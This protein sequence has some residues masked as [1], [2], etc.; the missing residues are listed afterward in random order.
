MSF[1][2]SSSYGTTH[3]DAPSYARLDSTY[4]SLYALLAAPASSS[5]HLA[6]LPPQALYSSLTLYLS[7][8]PNLALA[9]FVQTLATSRCLWF[10]HDVV[11]RGADGRL[12]E[13]LATPL[14]N[15][16]SQSA[17]SLLGR[18]YQVHLAAARA[19]LSRID[20]I[21]ATQ[22]G[23]GS[24]SSQ[25][26]LRAWVEL[27]HGSL[28]D[29][30]LDLRAPSEHMAEVPVPRLALLTGLVVGLS[31]YK[32]QRGDSPRGEDGKSKTIDVRTALRA[33]ESHW[34]QAFGDAIQQLRGIDLLNVTPSPSETT[35]QAESQWERE[36]ARSTG[37]D[38]FTIVKQGR[39]SAEA[40][41]A[42]LV[43][44][45]LAAQAASFVSDRA[46]AA[47]DPEP[48]LHII[49]L[50]VL[51]LFDAPLFRLSLVP[52]Q[53]INPTTHA[54]FNCLGPLSRLLAIAGESIALKLRRE[55]VE[56]LL[57]GSDRARY[58]TRHGLFGL[59]AAAEP[60]RRWPGVVTQLL[61]SA[62]ELERRFNDSRLGSTLATAPEEA[63][64]A[65][66]TETWT[67]LKSF[68]FLVVQFF[69]SVLNGLVTIL[70]SP[71]TSSVDLQSFQ[72][73]RGESQNQ[74]GA[75]LS[76]TLSTTSNIPPGILEVLQAQIVAIM[77]LTF[78]IFSTTRDETSVQNSSL[79][80][81]Q[82]TSNEIFARFT[83]YRHVFYGSLEVIKSDYGASSS[84]IEALWFDLARQD[85]VAIPEWQFVAKV[86]V[87]LDI[88]EQLVPALPIALIKTP[89]LEY[90]RPHLRISDDNN[91]HVAASES[92]HSCVL[93]M[94]D[95]KR[96]VCA[97]LMPF[98]VDS[99]LEGFARDQISAAQLSHALVTVV[100][101][102]SDIHDAQTYW[103]VQM[104]E[105][106]IQRCHSVEN[107]VS[108]RAEQRTHL[109]MAL[110][111]L[112]PVVN[113]VLLRPLLNTAR[114]Y[115]LEAPTGPSGNAVIK[116]GAGLSD[117]PG[118][119]DTDGKRSPREQLCG[120]TF[121]ALNQ[122]DDTARQEGVR[123]WLD[124]RSEFGI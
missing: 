33:A 112:L 59:I 92:A 91:H 87:F 99:L 48:L 39:R 114:Q 8:L 17:A 51:P 44:L 42:S 30:N 97:E 22:K 95:A 118:S 66:M 27:V 80:P 85:P 94:F 41:R 111:D 15:V 108:G 96:E 9:E 60:S 84:L 20:L 19:V 13:D 88:C 124:N 53:S 24:W 73:Q 50:A 63:A 74:E 12:H 54:L 23:S 115:I 100:A 14:S 46:L 103:V 2:S 65:V 35:D 38:D 104:L 121:R 119:Q 113:L 109:Q 29:V 120:R 105:E 16:C 90:C 26:R 106:A 58:S 68:L 28:L 43:P 36:F 11:D 75:S 4:T 49:P 37:R 32:L 62:A 18:A 116:E 64:K 47:L 72:Q 122:M 45:V 76:R 101:C 1:S 56:L 55:E 7:R 123:W 6:L 31:A 61:N 98:Y 86:T 110:I 3:T 67:S 93:A 70:P 57:L 34:V 102:L 117:A 79:R 5:A 78:I 21:L 81:R 10:S 82:V 89:V 83:T 71:V 52:S 77:H 25:R 69:D 107:A 40:R